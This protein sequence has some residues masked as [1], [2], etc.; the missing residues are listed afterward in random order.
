MPQGHYSR[1]DVK[2]AIDR[3]DRAYGMAKRA[4]GDDL[5]AQA[6]WAKY[7]VVMAS[8]LFE[9]SVKLIFAAYARRTANPRVAAYTA[10]QLARSNSL[11]A[12]DLLHLVRTFDATWAESLDTFLSESPRKDAVN[13]IVGN[14]HKIAHGKGHTSSVSLVQVKRWI[15]PLVEVI[16]HVLE[17]A[18][19]R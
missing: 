15:E 2:R 18:E 12:E 14:R 13:S 10:A 3:V 5:E 8:G 17:L 11:R 7:L 6:E 4:C 16:E 19:P 1:H 9:E